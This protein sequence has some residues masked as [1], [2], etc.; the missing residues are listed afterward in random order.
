[1][2]SRPNYVGGLGFGF[3]WDMGWMHDTLSYMK[4]DPVYRKYHHHL[5]SFRGLY[6]WTENFC[7]PLSHDEVVYGKGS[8][9]GKMPGDWWQQR[10][11]L[12]LLLGYMAAQPGKKLMFMGGEFGQGAEWNHDGSLDWHLLDFPDHAGLLR[13]AADVNKLYRDEPAMH[14]LDCDPAGFQWVDANDAENSVVTLLRHGKSS[15]DWI[16]IVCNFTPVPRHDYRV[17]VPLDGYW[18]EILNSD[19]ET[20]GGSGQGNFGGREADWWGSHGQPYSMRVS[21]PPLAM[22]AFKRITG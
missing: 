17:G 7:L 6:A 1:M 12:R 19:S 14:E 21:C 13:W 22:V 8:L 16:L 15:N 2:V 3:K 18:K 5:L 11:N 10:A 4:Q 20:Y 9:I